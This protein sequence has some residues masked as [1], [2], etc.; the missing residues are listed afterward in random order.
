MAGLTQ[1]TLG[2]LQPHALEKPKEW[3]MSTAG[4]VVQSL[5]QDLPLISQSTIE[6]L[7]KESVSY[8]KEN[9]GFQNKDST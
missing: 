9:L 1:R 3:C 6:L 5:D 2:L 8:Q 4:A 7:M